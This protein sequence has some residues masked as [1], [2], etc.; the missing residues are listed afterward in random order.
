MQPARLELAAF[1]RDMYAG[2]DLPL[3][4]GCALISPCQRAGGNISRD[5]SCLMEVILCRYRTYIRKFFVVFTW[6]FSSVPGFRP[7]PDRRDY[8]RNQIDR[9][10]KH[11]SSSSRTIPH[12]AAG[13]NIDIAE[14][15]IVKEM[16]RLCQMHPALLILYRNY[17]VFSMSASDNL[18]QSAELIDWDS[19]ATK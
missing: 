18:H 14:M 9:P 17:H 10:G 13:L 8:G 4:Y 6:R 7:G 2:D 5:E 12:E 11:H 1:P 15:L 3:I 19:G 16:P